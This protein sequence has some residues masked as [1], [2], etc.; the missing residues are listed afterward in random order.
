MHSLRQWGSLDNPWKL[1]K[2]F[3]KYKTLFV[4]SIVIYSIFYSLLKWIGNSHQGQY[5]SL[6]YWMNEK[7][8]FFFNWLGTVYSLLL[9]FFQIISFCVNWIC[10]RKG[11]G[12]LLIPI[13]L[14]DWIKIN[15]LK[16]KPFFLS[17]LSLFLLK[18]SVDGKKI[19]NNN[20]KNKPKKVY[21][22]STDDVMIELLAD[23]RSD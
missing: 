5:T 12:S 7:K 3:F 23:A 20:K 13:C 19:N 2:C 6:K 10:S 17:S 15:K 9:V 4:K 22:R 11:F 8:N 14:G 16:Q 21:R 1:E 18:F